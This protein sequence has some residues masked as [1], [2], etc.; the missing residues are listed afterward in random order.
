MIFLYILLGLIALILLVAAVI[1]TA[2]NIE[3][4]ITINAPL[5]KV[6]EHTK[7]LKALNEWNPW[8]AKDPDIKLDYEGMDGTVGS[9][10]RWASA[11]KNVGEGCQTL[12]KIEDKTS[13][14]SRV[15]FFKPFK[16]TGNAL[17]N[18]SKEASA[19][20][21]TW[22]MESSTP[23]PMN[24]IKLLGVIEKNMNADF[25]TGLSKLKSLSEK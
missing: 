18:L 7:S 25:N 24:I 19:T 4:S 21:V 8:M 15:D 22:R 12:T 16:G 14:L 2:W 5:E 20:K 1:G 6:W 10:F 23:Y 13:L 9:N 11:I 17:L 3:R